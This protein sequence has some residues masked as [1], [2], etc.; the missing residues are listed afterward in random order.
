MSKNVSSKPLSVRAASSGLAYA[1]R[2]C[3]EAIGT[4]RRLE[5]KFAELER[6]GVPR[7]IFLMRGQERRAELAGV[8]D[9]MRRVRLSVETSSLDTADAELQQQNDALR[10]NS[11]NGQQRQ[12]GDR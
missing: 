3:D 5:E 8:L 12:D 6:G 2:L 4:L 11:D 1:G 10:G 7:P 9:F